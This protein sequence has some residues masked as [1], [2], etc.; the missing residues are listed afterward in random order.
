MTPRDLTPLQLMKIAA[1]TE[2]EAIFRSWGESRS[3]HYR[4]ASRRAKVILALDEDGQT[5]QE[6]GRRIQ[7]DPIDVRNDLMWARD[8][9]IV[10]GPRR[11]RNRF[12]WWRGNHWPEG[13]TA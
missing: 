9:G 2:S 5:T 13:E 6:I 12:L 4:A 3:D 10:A 7:V 8:R 11:D 1:R